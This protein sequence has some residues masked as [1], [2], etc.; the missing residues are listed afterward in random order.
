[1]QVIVRAELASTTRCVSFGVISQIFLLSL[2]CWTLLS[3]LI[4]GKK[5]S[6]TT[7][8]CMDM[9]QGLHNPQST[10]GVSERNIWTDSFTSLT[11]WTKSTTCVPVAC[12]SQAVS[13]T[14]FRWRV[15]PQT[16]SCC[17]KNGSEVP[18]AWHYLQVA[19]VFAHARSRMLRIN[20]F[21]LHR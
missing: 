11:S 7:A 14:M 12:E 10:K 19:F 1:M 2:T 18:F 16:R 9:K 13:R 20:L 15:V 6:K 3:P 4:T 5:H 17:N 21:L 8:K